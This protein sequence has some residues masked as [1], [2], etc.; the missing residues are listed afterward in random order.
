MII[1]A[2]PPNESLRIRVSLLSL[3]GIC[4]VPDF[5]LFSARALMQ[6]PSVKR[7]LFILIPYVFLKKLSLLIFSEPAKSIMNNLL[8]VF[9][10]YFVISI[11]IF[12][13]A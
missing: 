9:C 2:F 6:F 10:C 8:L 3:Y 7:L 1:L 13:I 11:L 12:S 4:E 5:L